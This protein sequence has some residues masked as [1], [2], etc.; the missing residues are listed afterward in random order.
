MTLQNWQGTA[1]N[2]STDSSNQIHSDEMAQAYGFR[3]GLVPGVVISTYL[4][5]PAVVGWGDDWINH[6]HADIKILSPLYD[7]LNFEVEVRELSTKVC[8][9]QLIDEENTIC[10]TGR[11][12]LRPEATPPEYRGAPLLTQ[13]LEIPPA[14]LENM[15]KLRADGMKSLSTRWYDRQPMAFYL[16]DESAMAPVHQPSKQGV[17]HGAFLLSVTNWVLAANAYMNPWVHLQ[18]SSQYF[19]SVPFDTKLIAECAITDLFAKKGHEFVD[20]D[21]NLFTD[22]DHSPVMAATLRAIYKM[23]PAA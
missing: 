17:A 5:Q 11:L 14:T 23:R 8:E 18:T 20:V 6:G 4:M 19:Q 15:Q 1:F 12:S 9:V 16:K 10:G 13:D 22:Q 21:V 7:G 2:P 3:G